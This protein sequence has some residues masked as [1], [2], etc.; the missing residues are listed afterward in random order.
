VSILPTEYREKTVEL[1]EQFIVEHNTKYNTDISSIFAQIIHE[2]AQPFDA[3]AAKKFLHISSQ[4]DTLR[5]ESIFEVIPELRIIQEMFPN[6]YN[7]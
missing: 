3:E 4:I 7:I 2:L 6:I 1:L 5:N